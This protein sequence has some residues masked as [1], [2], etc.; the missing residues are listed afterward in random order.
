MKFGIVVTARA[1]SSRVPGKALR[2]LN[3][4]PLIDHLLR[5]CL[6]T[7]LPVVL[8]IPS[9]DLRAFDGVIDRFMGQ[10]TTYVGHNDDPMARMDAAARQEGFHAVIRVCT[11][12]IFIEPALIDLACKTFERKNLDYLYSSQFTAG[13]RFEIISASA[14][15]FAAAHHKGVE[16]VSYAIRNVT[17]NVFDMPVPPEY[18][19]PYRFLID[20]PEDVT[21]IETVLAARKQD[22][23]LLDAIE[24]M[25][26][27]PWAQK[28][29]Q[30]PKLTVY[31]CAYNAEKWI[32]KAMGS[33]FEQRGFRDME[34]LLVDDH[35]TDGTPLLMAEASTKFPNVRFIRNSENLGLASSSNVALAE[36]RG[37]FILRLDADDYLTSKFAL[38]HL[39]LEITESGKDAI[40]PNNYFGAMDKIQNGKEQ[41]H[42]GGA[43][44]RRGAV[45]HVKFTELL[46]GYEG[47]DFFLRAKDQLN[48][49]YY[50]KPTFFYRQR[51]GSL[52]KVDIAGRA[53]LKRQIEEKNGHAEAAR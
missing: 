3:G 34:Y 12:K 53:L 43:I 9:S 6:K 5:R 14:L 45:N 10:V 37:E 41:H 11:D 27:N 31:T 19:S 46:R 40:Y 24:F 25:D 15:A 38:E 39:L 36:A 18:C 35:S 21:L 7:E 29:N 44:F 13:S 16:H 51:K 32:E 52:S 49:G 50:G 2:K 22:C 33:V 4:L 1:N 47:Y 8:A 20:Y 23:G 42:I 30:L 48:I 28:L 26:S 17:K